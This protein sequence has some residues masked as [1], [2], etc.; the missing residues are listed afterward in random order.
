VYFCLDNCFKIQTK[1]KENSI[2]PRNP[3]IKR[4]LELNQ[5]GC[6]NPFIS[7]S[8]MIII[9]LKENEWKIAKLDKKRNGREN[10]K[11]GTQ[12]LVP[13]LPRA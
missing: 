9:T 1:I 11:V 10:I 7:S 6:D 4:E 12:G 2:F 3:R 5:I 8:Q 13:A